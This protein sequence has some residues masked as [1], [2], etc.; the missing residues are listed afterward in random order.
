VPKGRS[1][2]TDVLK[3]FASYKPIDLRPLTQGP[4]RDLTDDSDPLQALLNESAGGTRGVTSALGKPA[5]LAAW[6]TVQRV[7]VVKKK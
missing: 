7:L 6:N 1:I 3:V 4:V 2:V 5:D